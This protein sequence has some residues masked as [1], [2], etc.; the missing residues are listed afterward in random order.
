MQ[1]P[2]Q[3]A[4]EKASLPLSQKGWTTHISWLLMHSPQTAPIIN[5]DSQGPAATHFKS[6]Q[7]N[8]LL[9]RQSVT[10]SNVL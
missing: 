3:M 9:R 2:M 10:I 1:S 4:G 6:G 5:Q 7:S 8:T